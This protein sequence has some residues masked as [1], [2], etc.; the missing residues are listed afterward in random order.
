MPE[1][2]LVYLGRG[3]EAAEGAV[4]RR[5]PVAAHAHGVDLD[6]ERRG[7][8]GRRLGVH[9]AAVVLAVG[10]QDDHLG[11]GLGVAEPGR[12]RREGRPD[13][14]PVLDQ[15]HADLLQHRQQ[16][17]VVERQRCLSV[18]LGGEHDQPDPVR[19]AP[20]H[21]LGGD[22]LGGLEPV[23]HEV[24]GGHRG[25]H[26]EREH[27]VDALGGPLDGGVALLG[28]RQPEQPEREGGQQEAVRELPQPRPAGRPERR[29]VAAER[30]QHARR[31]PLRTPQRP[32]QRG[33]GEQA[34][35]PEG[36]GEGHFVRE[37]GT[38]KWDMAEGALVTPALA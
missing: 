29:R 36:R 25:G 17:R 28:P 1:R 15:A 8:F 32:R 9:L 14:R 2:A 11:G 34:E 5:E 3:P 24:L 13:R 23:R 4:P 31:L 33:H 12:R 6:A 19:L 27:D 7:G 37:M 22:G 35:E 30:V 26:V 16:E 38:G 20:A 21:E 10:E 18:G